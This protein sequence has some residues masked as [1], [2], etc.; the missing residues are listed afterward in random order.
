MPY[1]IPRVAPTEEVYPFHLFVPFVFFCAF[2][3]SDKYK[4]SGIGVPSYRRERRSRPVNQ[5]YE[6]LLAFPQINA[7]YAFGI[8]RVAPTEEK[9][10]TPNQ[11]H[12][13]RAYYLN[14]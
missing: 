5:R 12:A 7:E 8:R 13:E 10:G 9:N 11:R 6:C 14:V 1:G 4:M 2:R 3:D